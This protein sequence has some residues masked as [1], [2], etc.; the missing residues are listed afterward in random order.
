IVSR[1]HPGIGL[2]IGAV[3]SRSGL[4]VDTIRFYE[5]QGLVAKPLRTTGG[6]RLY[7]ELD[8]ERL[9]FVSSAQALG[10][11]LAEIRELLLLRD[12]RGETCSH[13]HEL[14]N[15]KLAQVQE[16]MA[17]LRK[18]EQQLKRAKA[19]CGQALARHCQDHCPVIEEMTR[20]AKEV[21]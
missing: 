10:F 6:F 9:S 12:A 17:E 1:A 3:A 19:R 18:L 14:L 5:R 20:G 16:K 11:S 13:V 21:S 2:Q 7:T 4:T 15:R 8:I